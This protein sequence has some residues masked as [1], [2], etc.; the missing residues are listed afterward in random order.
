MAVSG[1]GT[2]ALFWVPPVVAGNL[3]SWASPGVLQDSGTPVG[4]VSIDGVVAGGT[5]GSVLFVDSVTSSTSLRQVASRAYFLT[6]TSAFPGNCN[7]QTYHFAR[8]N[9]TS[10]QVGWAGFYVDASGVEHANTGVNTLTAAVWYN[11]TAYQ[12]RFSGVATGTIPNGGYLTSDALAVTIPRGAKFYIRSYQSFSVAILTRALS[13]STRDVT[14]GDTCN[15][16]GA[17][18]TTSGAAADAGGAI[19]MIWPSLILAQS[20]RI[21]VLMIGDSRLIGDSGDSYSD[22]A[23]YVGNVERSV[24]PYF[25]EL[26]AGRSTTTAAQFPSR[27][28]TQT[29]FQYFTHVICEYG[30]NDIDSGAS[31]A[32]TLTRLQTIYAMFSGKRIFQTTLEPTTT[33][34]DAWV[35]LVNQTPY[36]T[37]A[38]RISV[39]T[40]I[41]AGLANVT[42]YLDI[43]ATL[44]SSLNSGKWRVPSYTT[45]GL[46]ANVLGNQSTGAIS[47]S[48][49]DASETA[50]LA[51]GNLVWND[52]QNILE[53]G[54]SSNL[55]ADSLIPSGLRAYNT[56]SGYGA[57]YE[58]GK[59]GWN[60]NVL[61]IGS[62]YAGTGTSR[63]IHLLQGGASVF[64]TGLLNN[65]FIGASSGN[66]TVTGTNNTALG[67]STL[68][69][70]T[71]GT[72]N[73][74]FGVSA[75]LFLT[76]GIGNVAI[77]N[78]AL[79]AGGG[80]SN[81]AIGS[82]A[83]AAAT[84]SDNVAIGTFAGFHVTTGL[85]SVAIGSNAL[86]TEVG[87]ADR[88]MAIGYAALYNI[89]S[90]TGYNTAIGPAA[91]YNITSGDY[92]TLIGGWFGPA[93]AMSSV[94]ALSDGAGNLKLDYNYT[95]ASTWSFTNPITINGGRV[96]TPLTA[97]TSFYV[98]TTGND[99]TGTGAVGLP[100]LT[101]QHAYDTIAGVY[102]LAGFDVVINVAAGTYTSVVR[103]TQPW[104]GGGT[105]S[106]LGDTTTP[107]NV[108]ISTT[109]NHCL[110]CACTLPGVFNFAGFKFTNSGGFAA[111]VATF[112]QGSPLNMNGKCDLG[113]VSGPHFWAVQGG[114]VIQSNYDLTGDAVYHY[115]AE[116]SGVIGIPGAYV[117]TITGARTIAVFAVSDSC[118]SLGMNVGNSYT[119]SG[120]ATVTGTRYSIVTNAVANTNGG[121]AAFFPGTIAGATASGGQYV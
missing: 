30:I 93:G 84:G 90:A 116:V 14:N 69:A 89:N 117:T 104:T 47:A 72:G 118:S 113:A 31:A 94:I 102:D 17:D 34:T 56:Y 85:Q 49:L 28:F 111:A 86:Y 7:A 37:D 115:L 78:N 8:D 76:A 27:T 59:F 60:N 68:P 54:H 3:T 114:I 105:V 120:G 97:N 22:G 109:A 33:S 101:I 82:N 57:N 66:S 79:S 1:G 63:Y 29:V 44:E 98:A 13:T 15:F 83:L 74:C 106:L 110:A 81:M 87:A 45:D 88:Q 77:G 80:D 64:A 75:G 50:V 16:V 73:L 39:N 26:N 48:P 121:G 5:A 12:L 18:Q 24:G 52:D 119:L 25:A 40:S 10:L 32:T 23:G 67:G 108:V 92:N 62:E 36:A 35:T 43:A 42:G 61:E 21:A 41:R 58:R 11:G 70:V 4:G 65:T 91:G 107:S 6:N 20:N 38:A 112:N 2:Q 46:H 71:T 55:S 100:W 99:S 19:S 95:T 53:I 96:R 51:E 103:L 9:I